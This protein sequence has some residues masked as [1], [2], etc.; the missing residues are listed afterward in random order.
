MV[1][2]LRWWRTG[3]CSSQWR[4]CDTT[5]GQLLIAG[6]PVD[7][8]GDGAGADAGMGAGVSGAPAGAMSG[9]D[10][11]DSTATPARPISGCGGVAGSGCVFR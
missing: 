1:G 4:L 7:A 5:L 3:G 2:T 9:A 11:N 8:G 6:T 10:D